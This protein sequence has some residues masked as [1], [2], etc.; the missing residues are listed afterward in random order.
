MCLFYPL[1]TSSEYT[2]F[3][4]YNAHYI[5]NIIYAYRGGCFIPTYCDYYIKY[6]KSS[7]FVISLL[8]M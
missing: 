6:Y 7:L 4:T 2:A 1:G 3:I 8:I 5:L